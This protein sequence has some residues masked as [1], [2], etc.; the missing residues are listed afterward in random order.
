MWHAAWRG[1]RA[2]CAADKVLA[3]RRRLRPDAPHRTQR[4]PCCEPQARK[5]LDLALPPRSRAALCALIRPLDDE[6]GQQPYAGPCCGY[7]T[8]DARG[9]HET[10][11][12]I[13]HCATDSCIRA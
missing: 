12:I 9:K 2:D 10:C 3:P 4:R 6:S 13:C 1:L 7:L 11:Q 5:T 8:L